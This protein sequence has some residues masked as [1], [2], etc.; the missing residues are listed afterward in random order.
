[1]DKKLNELLAAKV[2]ENIPQNIKT[3]DYLMEALEI[4]RESAYRRMRGEIPFTFNEIATLSLNLGFTV[5]EIIGSHKKD[6]IF[7]DLKADSSSDPDKSFLAMIQDYYD[8]VDGISKFRDGEILVTLNRIS[9]FLLIKFDTLFK[10]FYYKWIHQTYNIPIYSSFSEMTIPPE[11]IAMR[12]QLKLRSDALSNVSFILDRDLFLPTVREIQYYYNRRLLSN[13]DVQD[14]K[15][16]LI[17][18]LYYIERTL[19][20]GRNENG[21]EYYFYVSALNIET[22]TTYASFGDNYAS[23]FW[24]Y[25]LHAVVIKN[26][27]ICK[28][29]KKWLES[30][31]KSSV[32]VTQSNEMLQEEFIKRQE[33]HIKELAILLQNSERSNEI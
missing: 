30:M 14:M 19:Q 32:L 8:Y 3:I 29:H 7:F 6:R 26:Q 12:Q 33:G 5:D 21:Y 24:V 20:R 1:M 15:E 10:F 17:K 25:S 16:E 28:M 4:S 27:E 2:A 11:I 22:N 23:K 31:K 9:V 18:L 13:E